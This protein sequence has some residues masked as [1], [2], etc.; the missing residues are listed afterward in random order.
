M[1]YISHLFSN[2]YYFILSAL[3]VMLLLFLV[4]KYLIKISDIKSNKIKVLGIFLNLS[5]KE[6]FSLSLVTLRYIFLLY[7]F[8]THTNEKTF[9]YFILIIT[10]IYN[11]LNRKYL[12]V[13]LDL[14]NSLFCY[15]GIYV[16]NLIYI[17]NTTISHQ[18]YLSIILLISGIFIFIYV[19]YFFLLS[20]DEIVSSNSFKKR[21][22]V[23]K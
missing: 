9:L 1:N 19:T 12:S 22:R 6:I 21:K 5:N 15:Y 23:L 8:L 4:V 16:F 10:L 2:Y 17:Y 18:L 14:I 7:Y 3:V 13:F 20:T 11:L